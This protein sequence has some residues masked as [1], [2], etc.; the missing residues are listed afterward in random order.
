MKVFLKFFNN[1]GHLRGTLYFTISFLTPIVTAL[2]GWSKTPP[3]NYYAVSFVFGGALIAG[4]TVI[5]AYLDQHLS[6]N[7][8]PSSEL[9]Q[10]EKVGSVIA[11][12]KQQPSP[13]IAMI[14]PTT[15]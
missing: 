1:N 12:E 11:T 3:P 6:R 8:D 2:E 14:P 4:L 9:P 15:K 5:R 13:G 7:P 10:P